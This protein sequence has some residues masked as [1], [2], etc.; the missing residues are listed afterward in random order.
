[1]KHVGVGCHWDK[2]MSWVQ[3]ALVPGQVSRVNRDLNSGSADPRSLV[4]LGT[5]SGKWLSKLGD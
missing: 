4:A 3:M 1:M 5:L 2:K